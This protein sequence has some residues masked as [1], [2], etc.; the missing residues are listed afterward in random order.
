MQNIFIYFFLISWLVASNMLLCIIYYRFDLEDVKNMG[1]F[2][3]WSVIPILGLIET[4]LYDN[5]LLH[6]ALLLLLQILNS[7]SKVADLLLDNGLLYVLCN[8]VATLNGLEK[9]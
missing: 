1:L 7:C 2:Q 8:T 6:N 3:K 5:V 4:S 9:M